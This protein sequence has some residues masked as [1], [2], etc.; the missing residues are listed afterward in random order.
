MSDWHSEDCG[1]S[2]DGCGYIAENGLWYSGPCPERLKNKQ[3]EWSEGINN[4]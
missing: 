2:C 4:D 3:Q 1:G